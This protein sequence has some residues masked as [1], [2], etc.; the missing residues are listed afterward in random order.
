MSTTVLPNPS[1]AAA[2]SAAALENVT[3][4]YGS[5][6]ALRN[7]SLTLHP[8][9]VVALLG[10]NGAGK[11]TAVKLLLGLLKPS[12][13][14]VS[15]FGQSPTERTVRQRIGAMLQVARVPETL[16]VG[17]YLDL[18]RSYYPHP[19]PTAQIVAAAGLD[20]IEKRQFKDLSGG[21]KQRMLFALALCGDPDLVFLDEPTLGMDIETRHNL[22]REVRSLAD[23]G[24]TVL[25]TTH[26]L[27]E[28]DTLADRILVIAEGAVVA[29]GTPTEIKSRV[30][31]RKIKCVTR[32]TDAFLLALEGVRSVEATG[33]G[34][35]ITVDAAEDVLR[36]MLAADPSL[37]S[38]EVS[39]PALEDAFLALT[40]KET[41]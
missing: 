32:L 27:E 25:L 15:V 5:H 7:L 14:S 9:E 10:P 13:G 17:E 40:K 1:K 2:A 33:A 35:T 21:Q 39:S 30:T 3:H 29:Q 11:T 19:L 12:E 41:V 8:G 24:K 4:R 36:S 38:L 18:F 20:G 37:H 23:R 28:A 22:W 26:Y 34:I 6:T 16:A 31:G